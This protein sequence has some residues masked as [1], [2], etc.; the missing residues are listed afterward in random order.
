VKTSVSM[1]DDPYLALA[2]QL[3]REQP[4][5]GWVIAS[6]DSTGAPHCEVTVEPPIAQHAYL[7]VD[8]PDRH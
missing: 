5:T 3:H 1:T 4:T 8:L 7:V 6:V 2:E